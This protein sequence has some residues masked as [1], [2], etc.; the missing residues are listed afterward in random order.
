MNEFFLFQTKGKRKRIKTKRYGQTDDEVNRD[1]YFDDSESENSTNEIT[2]DDDDST[3]ATNCNNTNLATA[4]QTQLAKVE[5]KV[6][7]VSS[8]VQK[9]LRIVI[10]LTTNRTCDGTVAPDFLSLFP[11]TTEEAVDKFDQ[12]L[13]VAAFRN[14]V[15]IFFI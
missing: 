14:A 15:V 7:D 1:E 4:L 2:I 6:E 12:D 11:L 13:S 3:V 10:S 9:I 8:T 5:A